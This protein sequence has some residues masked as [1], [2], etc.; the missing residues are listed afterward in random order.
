M[1]LCIR[2]FSEF[3]GEVYDVGK[4]RKFGC[5]KEKVKDCSGYIS[6][7]ICK[8]FKFN[9]F[10]WNFGEATVVSGNYRL[11]YYTAERQHAN[12]N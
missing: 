3:K 4:I 7:Y 2:L 5:D 6:H 12:K 9:L 10:C 1:I 8:G 11:H